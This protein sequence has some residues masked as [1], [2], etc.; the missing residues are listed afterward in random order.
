MSN[1][2][3]QNKKIAVEYIEQVGGKGETSLIDKLFDENFKLT[4]TLAGTITSR[5]VLKDKINK[6]RASFPDFTTSLLATPIAEASS[7]AVRYAAQGTHSGAAYLDVPE[8]M[9]QL[10]QEK[11]GKKIDLTGIAWF[12]LKEGKIVEL[13]FE[14][15]AIAVL[16]QLGLI[17]MKQ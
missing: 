7:V 2:A 13:H 10:K 1:T 8:G 15:T 4:C 6:I 17:E 16:K 14:E 3:E 12:D 9:P 11:T 5:Q